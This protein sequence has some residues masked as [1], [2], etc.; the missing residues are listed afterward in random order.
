M[1]FA[2]VELAQQASDDGGHTIIDVKTA[3]ASTLGCSREFHELV[4]NSLAVKLE[5]IPLVL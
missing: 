4:A 2:C 1:V 5:E 3:F